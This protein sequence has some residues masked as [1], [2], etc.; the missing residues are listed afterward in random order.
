MILLL[1][2]G[3]RFNYAQHPIITTDVLIVGGGASGIS[4]GIQ[5]ARE[6][7]NTTIVEQ[8]P[9]LGGMLTGAGVSA[10]DGN[11]QLP[12][13]IWGEFRDSIYAHYGGPSKVA[14][15]WVSNT[16]FEPAVGD[17]I[18]KKI[19]SSIPELSIDYNVSFSSIERKNE[20]WLVNLKDKKGNILTYRAS[21]VIDA[22]EL[23]EV[24]AFL[25]IPFDLGMEAA[26]DSGE[27]YGPGSSNNIIQDL[28]YTAIL[29]QN[30][31]P[32]RIKRPKDYDP[33]I[34]ECACDNSSSLKP[35][36]D[37]TQMLE[38]ARLP[39]NKYL[40]NWPNC[41]NDYYVNLI[42]L[43]AGE[44]EVALQNAKNKTLQF[45][46]YIQHELGFKDLRLADGE[47]PTKDNLP[48]I[49]YH[50]ESRRLQGLVR[51]KVHD[52]EDPYAQNTKYYRTGIAVGDYP[53]DH[54]HKEN[55]KAPKIDFIGIKVPSYAV[56][57]GVLIPKKKTPN[58]LVAE[59]SISVSNIVNG[60][61]RLQPVVLGIGQ[62]AGAIAAYCLVNDKQPWDI[63]IRG[64][65]QQL[66]A[67][68]A[69]I[70]PYIDVRPTDKNFVTIQ[71]IGA[72]GLLKGVGVPYKWA[73]QTWFYPERT[74]SE[75][76]MVQGFTDFYGSSRIT[77]EGS[78]NLLTEK[79][80]LDLIAQL[81]SESEAKVA[82]YRSSL[83]QSEA[84]E[85]N[86]TRREAALLIDRLIDPFSIAVNFEGIPFLHQP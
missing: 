27:Q 69:Y 50:R 42:G 18:L 35:T 49:P 43:S 23:G 31:R 65:Q 86:M 10:I 6:G 41:G 37:C 17:K 2:L 54:H 48:L 32:K 44:K 40:I 34:F 1:F 20:H 8:G 85:K 28:T 66:L 81:N 55:L 15:G 4:A 25:N 7:V 52:L 51:L 71:K 5:S 73:N 30:N 61:T 21:F 38:Y 83:S 29:E 58:F 16:L 19:A 22:T 36:K 62:A 11:H 13:G 59:K 9:W 53:I 64:V 26:N 57:A 33:S 79:F 76:E 56:P 70:M 78:G 3:S 67:A 77:I 80:L 39:N 74:I 14:T 68:K 75:Y 63:D 24:M 60:T 46:Y 47:F 45:L 84:I 82:D 72:T 12:S